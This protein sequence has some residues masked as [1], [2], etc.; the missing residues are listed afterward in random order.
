MSSQLVSSDLLLERA[1]RMQH[2]N[3]ALASELSLLRSDEHAIRHRILTMDHPLIHR[4]CQDAD[5]FL[6]EKDIAA[7]GVEE[8]S[9]DGGDW[10]SSERGASVA[11]RSAVSP[12]SLSGVD[13]SMPGASPASHSYRLTGRQGRGGAP[14][15]SRSEYFDENVSSHIRA[16]EL[17]SSTHR[18]KRH[19]EGGNFQLD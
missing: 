5:V 11:Q 3:R 4:W 8:L 1:K 2:A 7:Q 18:Q 16:L 12:R 14:P 15:L 17:L 19:T 13:A 6:R 9:N 10:L